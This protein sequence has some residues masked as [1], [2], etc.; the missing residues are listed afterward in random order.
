MAVTESL[1]AVLR[2]WWDTPAG[3]AGALLGA[4]GGGATE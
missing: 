3:V 1:W 2:E 4:P